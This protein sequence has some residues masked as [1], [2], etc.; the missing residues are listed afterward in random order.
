MIAYL[1]ALQLKFDTLSLETSDSLNAASNRLR[2]PVFGFSTN[3]KLE[4]VI[5][6]VDLENEKENSSS[7]TL[8]F[9]QLD[10]GYLV[11]S[12]LLVHTSGLVSID[13]LLESDN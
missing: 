12:F 8:A 7:F 9:Q 4:T 1:G 2:T 3:I 11:F 10:M 13:A 5:F 6:E